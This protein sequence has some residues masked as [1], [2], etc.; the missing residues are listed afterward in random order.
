MRVAGMSAAAIHRPSSC[1]M[2]C[3]GGEGVHSGAVWQG[4][5]LRPDARH[6]CS[7]MQQAS[8]V[9]GPH[10]ATMLVPVATL[11]LHVKRA[12]RR[13]SPTAQLHLHTLLVPSRQSLTLLPRGCKHCRLCAWH[14]RASVGRAV[15]THRGHSP[16][17]GRSI[18]D[19]RRLHPAGH[20]HGGTPTAAPAAAMH[21]KAEAG[22]GQ[23]HE[24][25]AVISQDASAVWSNRTRHVCGM[26]HVC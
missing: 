14:R 25:G 2:L 20:L 15:L 13:P 3:T 8:C 5:V 10:A 24:R 1:P 16:V 21:S 26:W 23:Q 7:R 11:P 9:H 18:P 19:I 12:R 22:E 4:R 6:R 17:V